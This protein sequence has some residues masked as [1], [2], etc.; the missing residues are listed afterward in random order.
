MKSKI[1]HNEAYL[2]YLQVVQ[3]I[4]ALW[5]D[6]YSGLVLSKTQRIVKV[7]LDGVEHLMCVEHE[8]KEGYL[9][10][11]IVKRCFALATS[12]DAISTNQCQEFSQLAC[13]SLVTRPTTAWT[14][15]SREVL[16]WA[17]T[18]L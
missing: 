9:D 2:D 8:P 5:P 16:Q 1:T 7:R 13:F 10:T 4:Q 6:A 12:P 17:R 18:E 11:N 14:Q 15:V 3:R